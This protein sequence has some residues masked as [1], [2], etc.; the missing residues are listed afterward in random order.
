M[1]PRLLVMRPR[2]RHARGVVSCAHLVEPIL[3][4]V[5]VRAAGRRAVRGRRARVRLV[6]AEFVRRAGRRVGRL[7]RR[8]FLDRAEARAQEDANE[9]NEEHHLATARERKFPSDGGGGRTRVLRW[10]NTTPRVWAC[11][12]RTAVA[13]RKMRG[14]QANDE[15]ATRPCMGAPRSG[16]M[17]GGGGCGAGAARRRAAV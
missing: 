8:R 2:P 10:H 13:S 4:V 14:T 12:N 9:D 1:P 11:S 5:G 6:R 3:R 7:R 16:W 15:R 17:R